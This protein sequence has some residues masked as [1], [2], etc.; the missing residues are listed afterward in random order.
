MLVTVL[1]AFLAGCSAIDVKRNAED[2]LPDPVD[3]YIRKRLMC[4]ACNVSAY[5]IYAD[6]SPAFR[7]RAPP[8]AAAIADMFDGLCKTLADEVGLRLQWNR[9]TLIFS[10]NSAISRMRGSWAT[11]EFGAMCSSII[12][13]HED[14]IVSTLR[15][16]ATVVPVSFV[17]LICGSEGL[18]LCSVQALQGR[19]L[20]YE[21]YAQGADGKLL[22]RD[23]L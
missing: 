12:D 17:P 6:L 15:K 20:S 14:F 3:P 1:F 22:P 19:D 21:L 11:H 9:P 23:E 2:H 13:E 8:S 7:R 18:N 10:V 4:S 5:R 16:F